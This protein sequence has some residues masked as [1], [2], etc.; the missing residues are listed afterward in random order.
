V[1]NKTAPKTATAITL[2]KP[3]TA[4]CFK[5]ATFTSFLTILA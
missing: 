1:K 5:E 3:T 2:K 4:M